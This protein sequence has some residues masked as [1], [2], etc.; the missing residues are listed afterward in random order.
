MRRVVPF[1]PDSGLLKNLVVFDLETTGLSAYDDEIIQIAALR[2]RDGRIRAGDSFATYARPRRSIPPFI[3][4]YTGITNADVRDAPTPRQ[5][6]GAFSAFCGNALLVAHNGHN[7]D[8]P[9]LQR[10]CARN[11]NLVRE[12]AYIDSMHLSWQVW[13]RARGMSHGL[14]AVIGRLGVRLRGARRHDARG[15][16]TLLADCLLELLERMRRGGREHHLNVYRC[17]LPAVAPARG[18]A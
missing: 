12:A 6:V 3:T 1:N 18:S 7:F 2:I 8:I 9:F 4:R 15:D 10:V 14:D 16:V 11:G 5:A 17:A 13:G